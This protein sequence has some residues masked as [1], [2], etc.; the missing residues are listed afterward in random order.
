MKN[1]EEKNDYIKYKGSFSVL[2]DIFRTTIV[3]KYLDGIDFLYEKL[4]KF[5]TNCELKTIVEYEN[6]E[7]G[8]Y[9]LHC[10]IPHKIN[11]TFEEISCDKIIWIEV[12]VTTQFQEVL[13]HLLHERYEQ[14]REEG[15]GDSIV[16]KNNNW[17]WDYN[18][19]EFTI[20]YMAHTLHFMEG[21]IVK[22]RK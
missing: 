10:N 14:T 15:Y 21:L 19:K 18:S 8:Y 3:V 12:Q 17:K 16:T 9:A 4:L 5:E 1:K 22:N 20:N 2:K 11:A 7:E 6:R 13:K